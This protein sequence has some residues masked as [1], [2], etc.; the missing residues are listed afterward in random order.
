MPYHEES[1]GTGI[2]Q[3]LN[4]WGQRVARGRCGPVSTLSTGLPEWQVLDRMFPWCVQWPLGGIFHPDQP[5]ALGL[6]FQGLRLSSLHLLP[7]L[8]DSLRLSDLLLWAGLHPGLE[9]G[10]R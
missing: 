5:C 2:K 7:L 6:G 4:S 1:G 8:E 9:E 3:C 10:F